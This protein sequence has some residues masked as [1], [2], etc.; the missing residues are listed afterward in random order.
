MR[1]QWSYTKIFAMCMLRTL[2]TGTRVGVPDQKNAFRAHVPRF[3]QGA[4]RFSLRELLKLQR[5]GQKLQAR[6]F[7][8]GPLLY[9]VDTDI[10]YMI[11]WTRPS[12]SV[13]A[14]CKQSKTGW[15]ED[16]G[17]RLDRN[18]ITSTSRHASMIRAYWSRLT[19]N[20][21]TSFFNLT[22]DCPSSLINCMVLSI[23]DSFVHGAGT[24][25]TRGI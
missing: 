9:L 20:P 17:T 7:N 10:I 8:R 13:F 3:E 12:P 21:F 23:T 14:Y 5:L 18:T 16:L 25:S 11:K 6:S 2:K 4:V 24:I 19:I 1:L 22:G 15:W